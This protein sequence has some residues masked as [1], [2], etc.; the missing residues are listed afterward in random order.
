MLLDKLARV[1][2][3]QIIRNS[4]P[5]DELM[6]EDFLRSD[7]SL[8]SQNSNN[9]KMLE[10]PCLSQCSIAVRRHSDQGNSF[11]RKHLI[12]GLPIVP[13]AYSLIM[14]TAWRHL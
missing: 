7:L 3:C 5:E 12:G 10:N 2:R 14:V 6:I 13:E 1:Y 9:P 4:L 11:K 8:S